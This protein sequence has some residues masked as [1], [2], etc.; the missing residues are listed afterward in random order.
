MTWDDFFAL[1]KE[2]EQR[3]DSGN[4]TRMGFNWVWGLDLFWY[5]QQF[6][7]G[8]RQYGCEV[9]DSDGKAASTCRS[10]CRCSMRPVPP[11]P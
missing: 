5:A 11:H 3:D 8:M 6:W 10:A 4:V 9:V 7:S 2:L 1:A